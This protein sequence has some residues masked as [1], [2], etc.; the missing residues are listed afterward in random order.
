MA[1]AWQVE[2]ENLS[3]PGSLPGNPERGP[4]MSD[5]L[6]SV[7]EAL[8]GQAN[9]LILRGDV[10]GALKLFKEHLGK[11]PFDSKVVELVESL[12]L[13]PDQGRGL[14]DFYRDLQKNHPDDWRMVVAL[15]R[16]YS[17]TGKDSLAVV[18][19]QKLLRGE[20]QQPDVWMELATCY[21]RLDK[22]ELALRALNS[23][24]D[25]KSDFAPA[26]VARV[27]YLVEAGELEEATAAT[28]FSLDVKTLPKPVRDWMDRMNLVLEQGLRPDE[29]F[30]QR[31]VS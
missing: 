21:R 17:R 28:I 7:S 30:L 4:A 27:R 24:I 1:D 13:A 25:V 3:T 10:E 15:A 5:T 6:H 19:L 11:D 14:V 12:L 31:P 2:M 22:I 16:S 26:H 8:A 20:T 18:Q 23:L 29:E 9:E